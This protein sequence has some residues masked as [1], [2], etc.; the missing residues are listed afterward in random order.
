MGDGSWQ[1]AAARGMDSRAPFGNDAPRPMNILHRYLTGQVLATLG[2][3]VMVFT[4][5]LLIGNVMK[6]VMTLL[7]NG[8]ATLGLVAQAVLLLIPYVWAF[9]LPMGMLTACLLTFGRFSADQELTAVRS[10]GVSL[11]ALITPVLLLGVAMSL[12]AALVNLEVGPRTRLL[13]KTII[14]R[15]ALARPAGMI[16][17]RSFI[18]DFPGYVFYVSRVSGAELRGVMLQQL[19]EEGAMRTY[20]HAPKGELLVDPTNRVIRLRLTEPRG[21]HFSEGK[22]TMLPMTDEYTSDPIPFPPVLDFTR[23]P[24]LSELPAMTLLAR[25]REMKAQGL[26][27]TP[28]R[29]Q[30]HRM[31]S[32]SFASIAFTMVGIPLGIRAHRRETSIGI[33]MALVLMMVYYGF[34]ITGNALETRPEFYPHLIVWLPNFIFQAIGA[35]LLWRANRG[36]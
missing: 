1:I 9:A 32:F 36:A 10:A 33:A 23:E 25:M 7:V 19:D 3:T 6:E 20:I 26:D 11:L 12:L 13:Y 31:V 4:F 21:G 34:I 35:V 22:L 15:Q 8:Q 17:E 5:I 24:R 27:V 18:R 28:L 16:T 29:V 14:A 30:L 2:M